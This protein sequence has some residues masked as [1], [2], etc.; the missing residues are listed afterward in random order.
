MSQVEAP[1][2]LRTW[3]FW[4]YADYFEWP[5]VADTVIEADFFFPLVQ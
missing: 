1:N 4:S 2:S 3:E 5:K